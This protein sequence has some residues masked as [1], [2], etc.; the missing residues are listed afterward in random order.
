MH[1]YWRGGVGHV[2]RDWCTNE[3]VAGCLCLMRGRTV[4][5]SSY[6]P[7]IAAIYALRISRVS[8]LIDTVDKNTDT[9]PHAHTL[10]LQII[11]FKFIITL[12][13]LDLVIN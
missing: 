2:S 9:S 4:E 7:E 5:D 8:C 6:F 11:I 10:M 3:E 13:L 12:F 1:D